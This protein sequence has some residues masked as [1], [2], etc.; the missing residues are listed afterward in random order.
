[1]KRTLLSLITTLACTGAFADSYIGLVA[2]QTTQDVNCSGW[3]TCDKTD[4]GFK[5]YGGYKLSK[6]I[7][8]ELAYTDFGSAELTGFGG[9]SYSA[10]ALST[11]GAFH[12][13]FTPKL[14]GI[15]RLGLAWVETDYGGTFGFGGGS[16][17]SIEPYIG[18]GL[19]YALTPRL[20]LTGSLDYM[21][22]GYPRGSGSAR[23]LGIGLSYA[24]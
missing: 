15:G 7:A 3:A 12:L 13:P 18:F 17:S 16:D 4:S 2:G 21:R 8:L 6:G 24:F 23:L 19:A 22:V 5:L 14:T 10:Q 20:S 1:M 11:G 9:S